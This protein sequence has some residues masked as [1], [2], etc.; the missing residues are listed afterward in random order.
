M[1]RLAIALFTA[2]AAGILVA[3]VVLWLDGSI[4][5]LIAGGF[6]AA[7]ATYLYALLRQPTTRR[8]PA[9]RRRRR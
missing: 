5:E 6:C 3:I 4:G 9:R 2:P 7:L 8:A 1:P